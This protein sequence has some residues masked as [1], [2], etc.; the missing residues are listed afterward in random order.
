MQHNA[1][2]LSE[3]LDACRTFMRVRRLSLRTEQSYLFYIRRYIQFH[4]RKPDAMAEAEVEQFLSHLA[5]K[6]NVSTSTQNLAFAALLYLYREILGIQLENVSALRSRRNRRIPDVLSRKEVACLLENLEAPYRLIASLTYGAGLRLC[7]V[8]RLRVK[9][10]D[11][12]AGLLVVRAGKGDKDRHAILPQSL[13]QSLEAHLSDGRIAWSKQQAHN[14][15]PVWMPGALSAKYPTAA[16]E[17]QWQYLF[18]ASHP[19]IDPRDGIEKRHHF[20][21][22]AL[23]RAIKRA[24]AKANFN[25]RVSPHTLRHSF[26]THLLEGG[27]DI[28]TVQDLLGHKDVRTTQIYLHTMNRPGLGVRSPLDA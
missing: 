27:Y 16:Y 13:R 24:A 11:F 15:V 9:D 4:N 25:K 18:P 19:A 6:E 28:R 23:Q 2:S 10:V 5:A 26:A 14:S 12:A 22:D 20:A 1:Q 8:Q 17:W 7:E 3:F 21:D